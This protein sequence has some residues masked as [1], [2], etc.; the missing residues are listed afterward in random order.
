[1]A[2]SPQILPRYAPRI[3]APLRSGISDFYNL[4]VK[5]V[6]RGEG[7]NIYELED[8][9]H[10]IFT[11]KSVK[12][13]NPGDIVRCKV[14]VI[15]AGSHRHVNEII[16]HKVPSKT[17]LKKEPIIKTGA[18]GDTAVNQVVIDNSPC[19]THQKGRYMLRIIL[20]MDG[21]GRCKTN[22]IYQ[23]SDKYQNVYYAV[24]N[25]KYDLGIGLICHVR[26]VKGKVS[27]HNVVMIDND[28]S[29]YPV[30]LFGNQIVTRK[31]LLEREKNKQQS[32]Q[33]NKVS[34]SNNDSSIRTFRT[35]ST[36]NRKAAEIFENMKAYGY[37]KCGK[38]FTCSCC[39]LT[40]ASGNGYRADGVELY[41]C[42]SCKG[43]MSGRERKSNSVYAILTPMGGQNK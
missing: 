2:K 1:M 39:G 17:K 21:A 36:Y 40:Y 20:C 29:S 23:L 5:T 16:I 22:Y 24:S 9:D 26:P 8:A 41:L 10:H 15:I 28:P 25:K 12:E 30:C 35:S 18:D 13:C 34:S 6:H 42:D 7:H 33:K 3:G 37:H 4:L 43:R 31:Q 19:L 27:W 11:A 38:Q 14:S 32:K